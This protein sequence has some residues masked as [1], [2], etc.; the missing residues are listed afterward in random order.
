MSEIDVM[1]EMATAIGVGFEVRMIG[2]EDDPHSAA[3]HM[4]KAPYWVA[5]LDPGYMAFPC[6][7]LDEAVEAAVAAS[8]RGDEDEPDDVH[9]VVQRGR[10]D[11]GVD[12]IQIVRFVYA[13]KVYD[14]ADAAD[15]IEA[16][17][18]ANY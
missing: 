17:W 15:A 6:S 5:Q 2:S 12:H 14:R 1:T 18:L 4:G 7:T 3:A 8:L 11:Q 10:D 13:G 16:F 9:I